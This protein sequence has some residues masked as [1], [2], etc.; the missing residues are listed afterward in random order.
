[1]T[2]VGA[3]RLGLVLVLLA[4]LGVHARALGCG[5]AYDDDRFVVKNAA[6]RTLEDPLRFFTDPRTEDPGKPSDIYRPLRTLS[7]AVERAAFGEEAAGFHAVSLLFHAANAALLYLLLLRLGVAVPA[8]ALGAGL[9]AAHPATVEAVAWVGARADPMAALFTLLAV[10]AWVRARGA[11]RWYAASVGAGILACLSKEAA[12]VFPGFLVLADLARPDGGAD[13]ARSRWRLLVLPAMVA[14]VYFVV[15]RLILGPLGHLPGWWGGSYGANLGTAARAAGFQVL[16]ALFPFVPSIDW[17]L[18]ASRSLLEPG[19]V[20]AGLLLLAL[21]AAAAAAVLRGGPG[22]RLAGAGVLWGFLGGLVTSHLLF[23]VG[24]PTAE[25]FL[26]L[27]LAG[28]ALAAGAAFHRLAAAWPGPLLALGAAAVA[29]LGL[30][31][32]ERTPVWRSEQVLWKEGPA[33]AFSPRAENSRISERNRAGADL[34]D[35]AIAV[36]GRGEGAACA[37]LLSRARTEL[38][39]AAAMALDLQAWWDRTAGLVVDEGLQARV[40]RNIARV[41]YRQGDHEGALREAGRSLAL[42]AGDPRGLDLEAIALLSLGKVRRAGWRMEEA[43]EAAA[44]EGAKEWRPGHTGV[45]AEDVAAVAS[46]VAPWRAA[47]GHEGAAIRLLRAASAAVQDRAWV[48]AVEKARADLEAGVEAVRR[49]LAAASLGP[50][51]EPNAF[52]ALV[53]RAC[54]GAADRE[55]AAAIFRRALDAAPE[56]AAKRTAWALAVLEGDDREEGWRAAEEFHRET[57]RLYPGDGG[58]HLGLDRCREALE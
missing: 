31:A 39:G 42:E 40:R 24:I 3:R 37:D 43:L 14:I 18:P 30:V 47:R 26:Y 50:S 28:L 45:P 52:A 29:G 48:A 8:A 49:D 19:T 22:L 10:H 27:P 4:A 1:M 11:D 44:R 46:A 23:P 7:F 33:G 56:S 16:S 6:I 53:V 58:A 2:G 17:Y 38:E 12:V 36:R 32:A 15:V 25:R 9:F 35:R 21:L 13:F 54:R 41:L 57:L 20:A 34:L 5:F 55:E 51:E